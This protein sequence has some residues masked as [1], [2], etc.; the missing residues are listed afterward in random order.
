MK[1]MNRALAP[2]DPKDLNVGKWQAD[3]SRPNV[4]VGR[5]AEDG[6]VYELTVPP[7]LRPAIILMQNTIEVGQVK[8]TDDEI[9]SLWRTARPSPEQDNQ[10]TWFHFCTGETRPRAELRKLVELA[11]E[12]G[13]EAAQCK[14]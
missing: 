14:P 3:E 5:W 2:I 12:Y 9:L 4:I 1:E 6:S 8:L 7:Q 10:M 11:I 13:R